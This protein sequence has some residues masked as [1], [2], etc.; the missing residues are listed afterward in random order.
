[1]ENQY[2]IKRKDV[3]KSLRFFIFQK[4]ERR[5]KNIVKTPDG[6]VWEISWE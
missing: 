1:M 4:R 3:F 5:G 2:K 6:E